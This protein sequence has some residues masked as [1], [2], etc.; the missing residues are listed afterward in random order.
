MMS[1]SAVSRY[2]AMRRNKHVVFHNGMVTNMIPAPKEDIV[3]Y[4]CKRLNGVIFEN[5]T[6]VTMSQVAE[7]SSS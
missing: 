4:F 6:V 7:S 2:D 3:S 1:D 5:Q